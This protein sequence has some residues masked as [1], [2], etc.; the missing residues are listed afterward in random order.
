MEGIARALDHLLRATGDPRAD[1][2]AI[3]HDD[4][5]HVRA[6]A[7]RAA[8][9]VLAKVPEALPEIARATRA[10][11]TPGV[12]PRLRSHFEAARLWVAGDALLAARHYARIVERWPHDLLAMRLA[13]SCYF[14]VG[15][16][17][18]TCALL[19]E[20]LKFWRRETSGYGFAL[21]MAS[22]SH[23]EAGQA[24]RAER[25][26]REALERDPACPMGVHAVAHAIAE[27]GRPGRGAAWMRGQRAHWSVPSRMR[28]HNAW[29]LAMFD[30]E[31]GRTESALALLDNCLLP[32]A[33]RSPVDAC[34]ATSLLWRLA[35][36]DIDTG[37]RW[38]QLSDAFAR[39]WR[40]GFW[41][42][43]DMHAAIAHLR[44]GD[45]QRSQQLARSIELCA[46][47]DH[48]SAGRARQI[49]IPFLEAVAK[50]QSGDGDA[51]SARLI[52]LRPMLHVAGGSRLQMKI[53]ANPGEIRAPGRTAPVRMSVPSRAGGRAGWVAPVGAAR[54]LAAGR[55]RA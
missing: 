48:P 15:Q 12:P 10:M 41:P 4:P 35:S 47:Q 19:D 34:D 25:L 42:Y 33:Q 51:A 28:T 54:P 3:G 43:V 46:A 20:A 1:L 49:T 36:P 6:E 29:H 40:P 5:R 22:F 31:D 11:D 52:D 50:W 24:E 32:A 8:I 38:R 30:V 21:A 9:G 17:G 45:S 27:A 13:Q 37:A 14:F 7:I 18:Q 55:T 16:L 44:A 26:G 39:N 23:A 2:E 53:F